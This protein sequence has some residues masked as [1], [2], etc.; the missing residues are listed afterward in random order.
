MRNRLSF[1]MALAVT[2]VT[3]VSVATAQAAPVRVVFW[4]ALGATPGKVLADMVKEFNSSQSDV[5]VDVSFQGNYFDTQQKMMIS[6]AAGTPPDLVQVEQAQV[7]NLAAMGVLTPLDDLGLDVSDFVDTLIADCY[8]KGQLYGLPFNRST[9][10]LYYNQ[11]MFTR[12]GLDARPPATW[13]DLLD[14]S[15][16]LTSREGST[17]T[18][19]GYQAAPNFWF[20]EAKVWQN[21]GEMADDDTG[22]LLFDRPPAV[23]ALQFWADLIHKYNVAKVPPGKGDLGWENVRSDFLA[24]RTAIILDTTGM[25]TS[26]RASARFTVGVGFLPRGKQAAVPTGGGNVILLAR[27]REVRDA[28][29][30]FLRWFTAPEQ[31]ARWSILT[32]YMPVRRSA[33]AGKQMEQHYATHPQFKVAVD[34]LAYARRVPA[35]SVIPKVVDAVETALQAVLAL[36]RDPQ[37]ELQ[38]AAAEARPYVQEF[39]RAR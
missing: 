26:T 4:M 39:F 6:L 2:L 25:L 23:E 27:K 16:K 34:Q 5:F 3:V 17:V 22:E 11:D 21:G 8:Y 7:R 37:S 10:L 36:G 35:I 31:T 9:P 32:G 19:W 20:F 15:T 18:T 24:G 12:A 28:A 1:T 13:Q 33:I 30:K 29:A 14:Y 38:R